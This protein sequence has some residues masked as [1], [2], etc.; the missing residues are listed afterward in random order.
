MGGVAG[1]VFSARWL[2]FLRGDRGRGPHTVDVPKGVSLTIDP[3]TIV[4]ALNDAIMVEGKLSA[5]GTAASPI[6][7]HLSQRQLSRREPRDRPLWA[8]RR[9]CVPVS[10]DDNQC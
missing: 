9:P 10:C 8:A 1:F 5:V 7:F 4:K 6:V 3:G 2:P